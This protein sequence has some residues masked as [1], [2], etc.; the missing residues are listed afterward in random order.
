MST[1]RVNYSKHFQPTP[2]NSRLRVD[3]EKLAAI[4]LEDLTGDYANQFLEEETYWRYFQPHQLSRLVEQLA[5]IVPKMLLATTERGQPLRKR[6]GE[7]VAL[8]LR[9]LAKSHIPKEN[10]AISLCDLTLIERINTAHRLELTATL[11]D[12][13]IVL[14]YR[15]VEYLIAGVAL[16]AEYTADVDVMAQR[17]RVAADSCSVI[18]QNGRLTM[19]PFIARLTINEVIR[20]AR[21]CCG[22][23]SP[24]LQAVHLIVN[25]DLISSLRHRFAID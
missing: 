9:V 3:P 2:G 11:Q 25:R 18:L 21:E 13:T 23:D 24:A 1:K 8:R 6:L 22:S 4:V 10:D 16:I 20:Q 17:L 14:D 12:Q 15:S 5:T 7:H 19:D